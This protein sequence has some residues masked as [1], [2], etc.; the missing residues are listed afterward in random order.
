M[1]KRFMAT[2]VIS[3]FLILS[4]FQLQIIE[5]TRGNPIPSNKPNGPP[6]IIYSPTNIT[7]QET[8]IPLNFSV[9]GIAGW[10]EGAYH[11]TDVYYE[12]DGKAVHLNVS[13]AINKEQFCTNL[14]GL[15]TGKHTLTVY[16]NGS[17]LYYTN[18][19]SSTDMAPFSVV[20]NQTVTFAV[21]SSLEPDTPSPSPSQTVAPSPSLLPSPTEQLTPTP[22]IASTPTP[23]PLSSLQPSTSP[24][25]SQ[26]MDEINA[27]NTLA[28]ITVVIVLTSVSLV[29]YLVK[30]KKT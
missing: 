23:A 28:I 26:P 7:Y 14:I 27:G 19:P 3:V 2:V 11:L 20:T 24:D 15:T 30:L 12:C 9:D 17:G 4:L 10:W 6:V 18:Y 16:A 22:T 1:D 13:S 29:F 5:V 25:E 21:G 8:D